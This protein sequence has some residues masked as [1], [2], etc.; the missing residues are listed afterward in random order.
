MR[1]PLFMTSFYKKSFATSKEFSSNARASY[2][3]AAII[4]L[5]VLEEEVEILYKVPKN[6]LF[7]TAS[8][9]RR[10]KTF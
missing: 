10:R 7:M 4:E 5:T 3:D 1:Q 9:R 6:W 2:A 8:V